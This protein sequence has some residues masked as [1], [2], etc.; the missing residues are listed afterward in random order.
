MHDCSLGSH[1][2]PAQPLQEAFTASLAQ[3]RERGWHSSNVAQLLVGLAC[4]AGHDVMAADY[5]R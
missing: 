2:L 5:V 4:A 3:L 1:P